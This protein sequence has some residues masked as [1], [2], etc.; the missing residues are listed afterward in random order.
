MAGAVLTARRSTNSSLRRGLLLSLLLLQ[1]ASC[2][3]WQHST[4]HLVACLQGWLKSESGWRCVA[5]VADQQVKV[6]QPRRGLLLELALAA[7]RGLQCNLLHLYSTA[8]LLHLRHET[9]VVSFLTKITVSQG[10]LLQVLPT[11]HHTFSLRSGMPIMSG[12]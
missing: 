12:E 5:G 11:V 1:A 7:A 8:L 9:A 2:Q 3:W 4:A 10:Q 6:Q